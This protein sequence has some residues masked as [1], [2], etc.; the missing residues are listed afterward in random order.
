[1]MLRFLQIYGNTFFFAFEI[2]K[3]LHC[4]QETEIK[5]KKEKLLR[6]NV[7]AAEMRISKK[8]TATLY[9]LSESAVC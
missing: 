4:P 7:T 3:V 8:K 6:K 9:T 2:N 5:R 1:M